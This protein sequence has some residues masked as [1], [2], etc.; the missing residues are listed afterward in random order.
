MKLNHE[1]KFHYGGENNQES[2]ES[3][4]DTLLEYNHIGKEDSLSRNISLRSYY[5]C[6]VPTWERIRPVNPSELGI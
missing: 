1:Q 6:S 3:H 4:V 2:G 5:L